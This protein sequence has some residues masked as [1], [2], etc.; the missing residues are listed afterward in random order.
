M[1]L[2]MVSG[3]DLV[4]AL[5]TI[6]EEGMNPG[7]ASS[8]SIVMN[9]P[10]TPKGQL[11][12]SY[13]RRD[14][15]RLAERLEADL[16]LLGYQ[17]WRDKRQ[18]RSGRA[19]DREIEC[20][21]RSSQLVVALLSP[22]AVRTAGDPDPSNPD[23]ADSVCLD[24]LSFARFACKTPIVPVL[25][26]PCTPPFVILR[27]DYVDLCAWS[28]S[29]DQYRRGF[30]RLTAAIAAALRGEPP[31]Y[32][33]WDD[34]FRPF[35]FAPFLYERRRDFCGRQWLFDAIETWR[36]GSDRRALLITG[37]PG[38]A[39]AQG[40]ML[41]FRRELGSSDRTVPGVGQSRAGSARERRPA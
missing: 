28:D 29:A 15:E 23:D 31:P 32:R 26:A 7:E 17:V 21:L 27:L 12:L 8:E 2:E 33:R 22:H 13:G 37:E 30:Q 16:T 18:I 6:G 40:D 24:E 19:W 9:A 14:A 3:Y 11:F 25:A 5:T 20:A 4:D 10:I 41:V 34:R 36:T 35:D 38:I 39:A 1:M